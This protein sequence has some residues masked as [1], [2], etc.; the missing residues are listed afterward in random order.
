MLPDATARLIDSLSHTGQRALLLGK[1]TD[2][3]PTVSAL[4]LCLNLERQTALELS[5]WL[6]SNH[7]QADPEDG[8]WLSDDGGRSFKK[9]YSFGQPPSGAYVPVNLALDSLIAETKQH[10]S[11]RF[12][13][14]FQQMGNWRADG[15]ETHRHGIVLDDIAISSPL[16]AEP[17]SQA[18]DSTVRTN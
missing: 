17:V 2:G 18:N 8:I 13:I 11:E 1:L 16:L 6:Y 5:F 14:R 4:D 10:Y 12:V 7:D 9:A 15:P 3:Y